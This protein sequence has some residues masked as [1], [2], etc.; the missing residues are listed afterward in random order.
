[1]RRRG[2]ETRARENTI[3]VFALWPIDFVRARRMAKSNLHRATSACRPR[4]RRRNDNLIGLRS[5]PFYRS[6]GPITAC[7]RLLN[8]ILNTAS[9]APTRRN[10]PLSRAGGS[11]LRGV[12]PS[13]CGHNPYSETT[14]GAEV[15]FPIRAASRTPPSSAARRP[16]GNTICGAAGRAVLSVRL[17]KAN[18]T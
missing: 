13:R 11:P 5:F 16:V 17:C 14:R 2:G 15:E 4:R 7:V 12:R 10:G 18:E 6:N 3:I 8:K 1:M 9:P